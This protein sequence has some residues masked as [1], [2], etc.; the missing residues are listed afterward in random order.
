[1]DSE[2][3]EQVRQRMVVLTVAF[4]GASVAYAVVAAVLQVTGFEQGA[5]SG[6]TL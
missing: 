2:A 6:S 4:M 3:V 1:M 5:L